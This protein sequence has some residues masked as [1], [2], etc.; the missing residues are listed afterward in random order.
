MRGADRSDVSFDTRD[1]LLDELS[2]DFCAGSGLVSTM[3]RLGLICL[4]ECVGY[5]T[6]VLSV[7]CELAGFRH[8]G[9]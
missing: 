8:G 9:V 4:E 5:R 2:H 3:C 7:S 6:H 1:S